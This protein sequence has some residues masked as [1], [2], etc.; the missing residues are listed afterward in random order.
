MR[1]RYAH[2]H[3]CR[4]FCNLSIFASPNSHLTVFHQSKVVERHFHDLLQRYGE[5]MALDLTDKVWTYFGYFMHFIRCI[6]T[7]ISSFI[8][9][10][11]NLRNSW[12][13]LTYVDILP[14]D[15]CF[16]AMI[17]VVYFPDCLGLGTISSLLYFP[18]GSN[19]FFA[20]NAW[21]F[22]EALD[23]LISCRNVSI[24]F[25]SSCSCSMV[26]KAN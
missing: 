19:S 9:V 13:R 12:T 11:R 26:M 14:I 8:L 2:Y 18:S 3:Y 7:F 24:D 17:I 4:C 23:R 20:S 16:Q 15:F 22:C 1:K 25:F 6:L 21:L 10:W 5:T